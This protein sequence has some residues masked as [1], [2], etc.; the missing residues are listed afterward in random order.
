[1]KRSGLITTK[2]GM[3]RLYDDG[4]VAHPVTVLSVGDCTVI[5]N[6]TMEKN[7]YVA[8]V[9][10]MREAKAKHIAKPQAVAAEKAGVKPYRKVVEFRVSDDCVIPTGT[11]LMASHSSFNTW[12]VTWISCSRSIR[13][14]FPDTSGLGS[15][16]PTTTLVIPSSMIA[17]VQGGV[18]P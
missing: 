17:S 18:F 16:E 11:A 10:G 9:L 8:N 3:T 4:G 2:I 6:R 15:S 1:M 5:G 14:P 13:N 12:V 7:G